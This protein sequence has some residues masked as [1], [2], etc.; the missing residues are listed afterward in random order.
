MKRVVLLVAMLVC[1]LSMFAQSE[2]AEAPQTDATYRLPFD[3][4]VVCVAYSLSAVRLDLA[5]NY[6]LVD[7]CAWELIPTEPTS[8]VAPREGVVESVE[9]DVVLIRHRENIYTRLRGATNPVV[10]VG[11]EVRKGDTL[12]PKAEGVEL[13]L[14]VFYL[15]PNPDY[16]TVSLGGKGKYL[17]CYINPIFSTRTKCKVQ[18]TSGNSYT[19]KARTW[20]LPWE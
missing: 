13:W 11:D 15:T 19:T 8:V 3:N 17:T 6:N 7:F 1:S 20:C 10:K 18:L 16:G 2:V 5:R 12:A 14:E 4:G 9:G